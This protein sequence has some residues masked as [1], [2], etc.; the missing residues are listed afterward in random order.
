MEKKSFRLKIL[1]YSAALFVIFVFAFALSVIIGNQV[2]TETVV[3]KTEQETVAAKIFVVRDEQYIYKKPPDKEHPGIVIP[4]IGDGKTVAKDDAVAAVCFNTDDAL[5][6]TEIMK[7]QNEINRYKQ[8]EKQIKLNNLNA[9]VLDIDEM[10]SDADLLFVQMLNVVSSGNFDN[11]GSASADFCDKMT[12]RQIAVDGKTVNSPNK[13]DFTDKIA[14][15]QLKLDEL[16]GEKIYTNNLI[17]Q[18]AGY[19]IS[20]IDGYENKIPYKN[21]ED[22]TASELENI[23]DSSPDKVSSDAIG[24]LVCDYNWYMLA[25]INSSTASQLN[26]GQTLTVNFGQA[27]ENSVIVKVHSISPSE[28]GRSAVVF[29]CN[30]MNEQLAGLRIED[31]QIVLREF[32][33]YKVSKAALRVQNG[34]TGAYVLIGNVTAFRKVDVLYSNDDYVIAKISNNGSSSGKP[35]QIELNDEVIVKGKN[36]YDGKIIT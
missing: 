33:G 16:K 12:G 19:F 18:K 1:L 10:N 7:T 34:I 3:E 13:I 27:F 36:I 5:V 4:L 15:L 23:L 29:E 35:L 25:S 14:S 21:I 24:K 6:Y 2:K 11:F 26:V 30:L 22:V 17:A 20:S 32:T 8:L 9:N 28:K 31:A